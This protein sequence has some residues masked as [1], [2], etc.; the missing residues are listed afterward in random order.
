MVGGEEQRHQAQPDHPTCA[1]KEDSH[2]WMLAAAGLV[3]IA[4]GCQRNVYE[5]GGSFTEESCLRTWLGYA[6]AE[7]VGPG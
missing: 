7:P 6:P 5:M 4:I 3:S 1:R 2:P